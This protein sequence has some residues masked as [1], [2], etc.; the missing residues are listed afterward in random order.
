MV[1][2]N[3]MFFFMTGFYHINP[4]RI[5]VSLPRPG[6]SGIVIYFFRKRYQK[7]AELFHERGSRHDR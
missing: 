1:N 4:S 6:L 5:S 7:K 3:I 2:R